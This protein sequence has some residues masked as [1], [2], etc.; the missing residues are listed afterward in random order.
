VSASQQ[1]NPWE[2]LL[3]LEGTLFFSSGTSRRCGASVSV[4]TAA[5]FTAKA[6]VAGFASASV[7]EIS[8]RDEQW[9][10]IWS[11]PFNA[12]EVA[13]LFIEGRC[14]QGAQSAESS[15]Q[16]AQAVARLGVARGVDAFERYSY[17]A[18]KGDANYAV[19]IGRWK[20]QAQP[21]VPLLAEL[22]QHGWLEG[23]RRAVQDKNVS[24]S[25]KVLVKNLEDQAM[26]VCLR[27][28]FP[29]HWQ[30]LLL[31]LAY[32]EARLVE[33]GGFT[34][35]Q[36]LSPIPRLSLG[37][38]KALE[39]GSPELALARSL[40][41]A[42]L[43][44]HWL[45]LDRFGNFA[46]SDK[47]L[48]SD[49]RVVC[50]GRDP[51]A[52]LLAIIQRRLLEGNEKRTLPIPA[53][54]P[55]SPSLLMLL[56]QGKVDLDRS[57]WLARG[58][59]A[60]EQTGSPLTAVSPEPI[61][62]FWAAVRLCF[63]HHADLTIFRLLASGDSLRAFALVRQRLQVLGIKVPFTQ[64]VINSQAARRIAVSLAFPLASTAVEAFAL[65]LDPNH[66]VI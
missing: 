21:D 45:P 3:L 13:A 2:L 64:P 22:E 55:A 41:A 47:K 25:T 6:V 63:H 33:C 35:E 65:Q 61:D 53:Q 4:K 23:L 9:M 18:R 37:W 46:S 15:L 7:A 52:D 66:T 36:R 14:Q 31:N 54:Q 20:V 12:K 30:Q 5:P 44:N 28:G 26:E 34:V 49:V 60:L 16:V 32:L 8:E 19:P 27:Q 57:Y 48:A 56:L 40:A 38:L 42:G 11:R 17:M 24:N 50:L 43:R 1:I 51:E 59:S 62:P 29:T 58:L 10:P 39:D